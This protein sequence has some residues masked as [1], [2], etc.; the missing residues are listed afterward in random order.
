MLLHQFTL[1]AKAYTLQNYRSISEGTGLST[2]DFITLGN[3]L[4]LV[5]S[6]YTMVILA[7]GTENNAG[8][9]KDLSLTDLSDKN[10]RDPVTLKDWLMIKEEYMR[11]ER[12][13]TDR[14]RD[15][16]SRYKVAVNITPIFPKRVNMFSPSKSS[17]VQP[18]SFYL[19]SA[20][21]AIKSKNDEVYE[22]VIADK[23]PLIYTNTYERSNTSI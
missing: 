13:D 6:N 14:S 20:S 5:V 10:F 15:V 1:K 12:I 16:T 4:N 9:Y 8:I 22:L 17:P 11:F 2:T 23:L 3:D 18:F 19:V 21:S 7:V